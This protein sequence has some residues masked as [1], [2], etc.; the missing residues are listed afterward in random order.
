MPGIIMGEDFILKIKDIS[1][2]YG[3]TA[4]LDDFSLSLK[5]GEKIILTGPNGSG[6]TSL[7]KAIL[8]TVKVRKGSIKINPGVSIAYS[9]QGFPETKAPLSA[10]EVVSMGLYKSKIKDKSIVEEAMKK[11]GVLEL[12]NHPFSLLSGGEK[13]RVCIAQCLVRNPSLILFDEPSSFLDA[14]FRDEFISLVRELSPSVAVIL[15]S[16]DEILINELHWPCIKMEG[17]R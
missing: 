14:S 15:V 1:I 11:T 5:K 9:R 13:Q 2:S 7:L 4:V 8:G 17:R 12:S 6:K 10:F 3:S 16:H